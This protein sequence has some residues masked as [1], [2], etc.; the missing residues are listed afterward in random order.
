MPIISRCFAIS[1]LLLALCVPT[2]AR[3][4][5]APPVAAPTFAYEKR[6]LRIPMRDGVKLYTAVYVPKGK[7]NFPLLMTRTCYSSGPYGP[8]A[9]KPDII[10][11]IEMYQ[12]AGYGFVSQDVRGTYQ[13]EGTFVN[14]RPQLKPG[15]KGIDESTD[16]YDT[17][18]YL[19]KHVPGN[20]GRVGLVGVSY[21]GFYAAVGA[22]SHHPALKAVS[23][24]AP[25]ADWFKGDDVH[26]N[27]AFFLQDNFDF[28]AWF[29]VPRKGLETDH[30]GID[31]PR[32]P[33][34][35]Y[36]FFLDAGTADGLEKKYFQ[37]RS[38][39]WNELIAHDTYDAYWKARA[40]PPQMKNVPC[41]VLN[42]G[43][44]FDAEDMWG[45]L[46]TFGQTSKQS[47]KTDNFLVMGPW[48]H[49]QWEGRGQSLGGMDWGSD[50]SAWFRENVEFPFFERYLRQTGTAAPAKATLFETGTNTWRTF[51]QWPPK[52]TRPLSVYLAD[53]KTVSTASPARETSDTYVNDP[54]APTPYLADPTRPRR[55]GD[56]LTHDEAWAAKRADVLTYTGAPQKR[57]LRSPGR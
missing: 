28:S 51:A 32:N 5:G 27:G 36:A 38:P 18:D 57:T 33:N 20:N 49:G 25:C 12:K 26:H 14:V 1:G 15:E 10:G 53:N 42:V 23:P 54:N 16:T 19:I 47:P 52:T 6:E 48:S 8:T 46:N 41:A 55:P 35:A 13:S 24:Q 2:I 44:W 21:P 22:L 43:G 3:Q 37:S 7:T 34:G 45:P 9:G 31:I 11:G 29:D 4:Q 40:V 50:T 17:I 30:Q 56:L 39:Y